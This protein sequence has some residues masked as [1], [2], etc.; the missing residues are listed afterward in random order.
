MGLTPL[1]FAAGKGTAR[2]ILKKRPKIT[3]AERAASEGAKSKSV[4]GGGTKL[5]EGGVVVADLSKDVAF[6]FD[7][8]TLLSFANNTVTRTGMVIERS[9]GRMLLK[10]TNLTEEWAG[11]YAKSFRGIVWGGA[12]MGILAGIGVPMYYLGL[13]GIIDKIK[14]ITAKELGKRIQDSGGEDRE[15]GLFERANPFG[16]LGPQNESDARGINALET[17]LADAREFEGY[18]PEI[19]AQQTKEFMA[20]AEAEHLA[21]PM[22]QEENRIVVQMALASMLPLQDSFI[23]AANDINDIDATPDEFRH[24]AKAY[25]EAAKEVVYAE[26]MSDM[27][28]DLNFRVADG[29]DSLIAEQAAIDYRFDRDIGHIDQTWLTGAMNEQGMGAVGNFAVRGI[30]N[31]LASLLECRAEGKLVEEVERVNSDFIAWLDD[32]AGESYLDLAQT[33]SRNEVHGIDWIGNH[34]DFENEEMF[35]YHTMLNGFN[36]DT[37]RR[38]MNSEEMTDD[39][40][41]VAHSLAMINA[42]NMFGTFQEVMYETIPGQENKAPSR[43]DRHAVIQSHVET[44][45]PDPEPSDIPSFRPP[46]EVTSDL[47]EALT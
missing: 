12:S 25:R 11:L 27:L 7:A 37:R 5:D 40:F 36:D 28:M 9:F 43:P 2:A 23:L 32:A 42:A 21:D 13:E 44:P 4:G 30:A 26:S 14:Q 29:N 3:K 20:D 33:M 24:C 10:R 19:E 6:K 35:A 8:K 17:I 34:M 45:D 47:G 41:E 15:E 31:G 1:L 38:M 18:D 16:L 46:L 39:D 22:T